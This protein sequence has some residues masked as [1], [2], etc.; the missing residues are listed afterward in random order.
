[1]ARLLPNCLAYFTHAKLL[2]S[3]LPPQTSTSAWGNLPSKPTQLAYISFTSGSHHFFRNAFLQPSGL[4]R[5]LFYTL[6]HHVTSPFSNY[7]LEFYSYLYNSDC[8]LILRGTNKKQM[9]PIKLWYSTD[10]KMHLDFK[11]V[12]MWVLES[13]KYL[14]PP[15]GWKL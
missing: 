7:P 11:N 8:I 10:F 3:I 6:R 15:L 12:K 5:A 14:A 1:M 13:M 4:V 9:L 2:L